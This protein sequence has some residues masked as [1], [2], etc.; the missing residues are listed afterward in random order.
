MLYGGMCRGACRGMWRM[1]CVRIEKTWITV[2]VDRDYYILGIDEYLLPLPFSLP[3]GVWWG[4]EYTW[5]IEKR[6]IHRKRERG[7]GE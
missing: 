4:Y 7:W 5:K 3:R 6:E 1:S 2:C